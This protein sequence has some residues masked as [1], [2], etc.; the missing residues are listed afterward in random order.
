M[1]WIKVCL[2]KYL[3]KYFQLKEPL[4]FGVNNPYGIKVGIKSHFEKP[5]QIDGG[6]YIT[7]GD[8]SSIGRDAWLGAFDRYQDQSF[9]PKLNIGN[10]VRIGNYACITCI[11]EIS[12]EDG[13]LISEYVY[14]SDH[15]HGFDPN[16]DVIPAKQ[17][18]FTKGKVS[19]GQNSFIGYRVSILNGV[20]LGR[21]CVVGAH[22]VVVTSFPDYSIIAGVPARLIKTYSLTE[23]KWIFSK[24]LKND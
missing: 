5:V 13:C 14:V 24:S 12:I 18:L 23:K 16:S 4:E 17:P 20:T 2:R 9:R 11:D 1:Q 15:Y 3:N 21:N 19:I 10:N 22:S 7:I 8:S 6:K